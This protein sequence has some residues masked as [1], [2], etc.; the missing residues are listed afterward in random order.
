MVTYTFTLTQL[1]D[2]LAGTIELYDEYCQLH[3][4]DQRSAR[5]A[6]VADMVDGLDAERELYRAGE[7]ERPGQ[8]LHDDPDSDNF[9]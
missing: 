6:T 9:A 7:I 8:V 5:A 4:R 3:G 1:S 2:L